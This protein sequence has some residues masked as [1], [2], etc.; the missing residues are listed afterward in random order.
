YRFSD[1][2]RK[3]THRM[4]PRTLHRV[5]RIAVPTLHGLDR[6]LR[7]VPLLGKPMAGMLNLL[8]PISKNRDPEVRLL[9]TLD[10]YSPKYQSKHTYE[11]VFR[12]FE[13]CGLEHLTVADISIGVKGGK[14]LLPQEN[15]RNQSEKPQSV[16]AI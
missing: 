15:P 4:S 7:A 14:P 12:W 11:Q 16:G 2:Y 5:L 13:A 3:V 10:W 6:G 1:H 8:L 9:D